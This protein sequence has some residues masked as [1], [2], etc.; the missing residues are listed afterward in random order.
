MERSLSDK[1]GN[2]MLIAECCTNWIDLDMA[3]E[4]IGETKEC[5]ADLAKFQLYDVEIDKGMPHYDWV[6]DRELSFPQ[7][8][9]LFDYG[10]EIGMEVFFSVFGV[11][12]VD[13]CE[14][15]GV[16]RYKIA[17]GMRDKSVWRAI[18]RIGKR[19]IISSSGIETFPYGILAIMLYCEPG[20]PSDVKWLP[21]YKGTY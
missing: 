14:K 1:E 6:K 17:S 10:A 21:D 12:Y 7:A 15:I 11:K 2:G 4:M 20:Y 9:M 8:K 19:A 16:K 18:S 3:K 5:G 13:W